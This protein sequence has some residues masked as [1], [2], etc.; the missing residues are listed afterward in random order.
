[1]GPDEVRT[2]TV[3]FTC[4]EERTVRGDITVLV[5]GGRTIKFPFFAK[6]VVP[7]IE[8]TQPEFD[9]GNITTLGNA[10]VLP[11]TLTNNATIS[12]E[13]V[14][15]LRREDENPEAPEG[16]DCLDFVLE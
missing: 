6:T 14:L 10:G 13:L 16:V 4:R 8:I 2:I 9:F 15:D 5:R 11:M 7:R 3:R 1:M 12:A